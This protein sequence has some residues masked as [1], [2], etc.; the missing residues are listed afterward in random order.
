MNTWRYTFAEYDEP[1]SVTVLNE[2]GE[3]GWQLCAIFP[4][5]RSFRPKSAIYYFK[6]IVE[7]RPTTPPARGET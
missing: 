5:P 6:K 4:L 7:S 3:R 2:F 1:V